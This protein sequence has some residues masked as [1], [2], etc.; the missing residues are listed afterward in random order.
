MCK[1]QEIINQIFQNENATLKIMFE[2]QLVKLASAN[3]VSVEEVIKNRIYSIDETQEYIQTKISEYN[4]KTRCALETAEERKAFRE[5]K[6]EIW[7]IF[8]SEVPAR[9]HE[10]VQKIIQ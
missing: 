5:L 4:T 6:H 3:K 1:A 8:E 9:L 10:Y 2:K 7:R